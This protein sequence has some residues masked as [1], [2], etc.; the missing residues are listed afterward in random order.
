MVAFFISTLL[1]IIPFIAIVILSLLTVSA[2]LPSPRLAPVTKKQKYAIIIPSHNESLLIHETVKQALKQN[3]P[4]EC[5]SVVVVADNC[6]DDTAEK[7]ALAGARVIERHDKPGKGQALKHALDLLLEEDWDG[8]LVVDADSHLGSES[9]AEMNRLILNGK[10]VF[11]FRYGVLN[12]KE[13]IRTRVFEFSMSSFNALRLKGKHRLGIST[14][15]NGNGFGFSRQ[16][17]I[18]VPYLA[19]S[20]VEDIEYHMHLLRNDIKVAYSDVGNVFSQMPVTSKESESQRERWERGR[21]IMLQTYV[22]EMFKRS[23]TGNTFALMALL[24]VLMPPISI[25]VLLLG[26]GTVVGGEASLTIASVL[27]TLLVIH[28]F[29]SACMYGSLKGLTI[30]ALYIPWYIIWKTYVLLKSLLMNKNLP[31][32]RTERR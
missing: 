5:Y 3:Y 30:V 15:V 32:V 8:F 12:P 6:T 4:V 11:Q 1:L 21:I 18:Q 26:M 29:I 2:C 25:I 10:E 13:S 27:M 17:A 19:H 24:D 16:V 22:P 14:G 7:A 31:W 20:I 23:M 28:Y 9:V